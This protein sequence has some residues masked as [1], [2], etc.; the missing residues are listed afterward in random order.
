[1]FAKDRRYF[2]NRD[3]LR[4]VLVEEDVW[5][6]RARPKPTNGIDTA[7]FPDELVERCLELGCPQGGNVLDCFAG[8]GTTVRVAL[9]SGSIR[10]GH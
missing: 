1:M 6:I 2:F 8:S 3:A 5:T 10:D 7:P 4:N 9:K